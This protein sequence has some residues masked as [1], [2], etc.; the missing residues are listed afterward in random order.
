MSVLF[1]LTQRTWWQ[2]ILIGDN[3]RWWHLL[4]IPILLI[5][6]FTRLWNL[7]D[8]FTFQGDQGRDALVVSQLWTELDPIFIGPVTS[9]GNL[10]LGPFYY[11]FMAPFLA[12][13]YPSPIGPVYAVAV[14]NIILVWLM[15]RLGKNMVGAPVALLA[16][17]LVAIS[18][19]MIEFSRFSWNPNLTA[20][21]SFVLVWAAF[22]AIKSSPWFW[23]IAAGCGAILIQLHYLTLLII[24]AASLIWLGH[25]YYLAQQ[26]K[27]NPTQSV[28][29]LLKATAASML[30]ILLSLTPLVL[31]DW[32]NNWL[33][34]RGFVGM[35][36]DSENF[37]QSSRTLIDAVLELE[38]RGLHLFWEVLI[39]QSRQLNQALLGVFSILTGVFAVRLLWQRHQ[40]PTQALSIT[41]LIV[42]L[43]TSLFGL[44]FYEHSVFD[45]YILYLL[46]LSLLLLSWVLW[47]LITCQRWLGSLVV[48]G[49]V[50]W[51]GWHQ[52]TSWPLSDNSW[53]V[54]DM[55]VVAKSIQN[56]VEPGEKY[57]IVLLSPT[58]DLY[59]MNYRYWLS[60]MEQPA[61]K[62]QN[63]SEAEKL[64]IINEEARPFDPADSPIYE[65][66]VFPSKQPTQ[67]YTVPNGP[68]IM[69]LD[70]RS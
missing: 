34:A 35:F 15:F 32:R 6:A 12:I 44:A 41:I 42:F 56:R 28:A 52:V 13:T 67:V 16:S 25:L 46:P 54:S 24:P 8:S 69:V 70:S 9:V 48:V 33:N 17:F 49:F 1:K 21:V 64:F 23:V 43:S 27:P 10:Y 62:L 22:N 3:I 55:R 40:N 57:N 61:V 63:F 53:T 66:Q 59:G 29:T 7:P 38:G 39:G 5:A 36:T 19:V 4:L 45:H 26:K 58:K 30:L 37:K 31:F 2:R 11:Y 50:S 20:L 51:L 47:Q 14:A 60:T 68:E 18:S 65:V